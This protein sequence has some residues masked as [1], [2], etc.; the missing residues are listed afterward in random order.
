MFGGQGS[1]CLIYS[2]A[3]SPVQDAKDNLC[4]EGMNIYRSLIYM[5][6]GTDLDNL[7]CVVFKGLSVFQFSSGHLTFRSLFCIFYWLADQWTLVSYKQNSRAVLGSILSVKLMQSCG[8]RT[9]QSCSWVTVFKSPALFF[10]NMS[11]KGSEARS[12][13][14]LLKEAKS[15][16]C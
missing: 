12:S 8:Q 5:N 11:E 10:S 1:F 14:T 13:F 3:P 6:F 2:L 4:N 16:K 15:L 9:A 7:F